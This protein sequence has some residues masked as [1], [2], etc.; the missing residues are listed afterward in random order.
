[1]KIIGIICEY[2][3]FHLGHDGHI[4][5]SIK[6]FGEEECAVIGVMSGN[7]VQRGDLAIFN[8]HARA[9]AA[10]RSGA[11]LIVELPTPYALSSA[12]GFARGGVHILESTGICQYISFGSEVGSI[13]PL[14][15]VANALKSDEADIWTKKWLDTGLP[16]AK[17]RQKAADEILG[18]DSEVLASPN[19]LLGIEYMLALSAT[20]SSI[21]PVTVNRTGG[22][23]DG[24]SPYAA[25]TLR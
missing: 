12:E 19:N 21:T 2:N 17:A 22:A 6:I 25:S 4:K 13:E 7:Y 5:K 18:E 8:K 16:Y 14:G 9:E 3:P 15:R 1:M 11:D 10:V 24:N 23:H 20:N